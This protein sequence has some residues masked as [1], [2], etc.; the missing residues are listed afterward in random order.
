MVVAAGEALGERDDRRIG[1]RVE[2]GIV[3]F[4]LEFYAAVRMPRFHC[5][6]ELGLGPGDDRIRYLARLGDAD[7]AACEI[8]RA[9]I[10]HDVERGAAMHDAGEQG[11]VWD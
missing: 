4:L 7:A 9:G 2:G 6:L 10:W 1:S 5:R 11:R 8:H 3:Q